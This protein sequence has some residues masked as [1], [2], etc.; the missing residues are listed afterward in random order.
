MTSSLRGAIRDG[1][2]QK[3]PWE[4]CTTEQIV[5]GSPRALPAPRDDEGRR[6]PACPD[7]PP[8]TAFTALS[9]IGNR[10]R[11]LNSASL[12]AWSVRSAVSNALRC[13]PGHCSSTEMRAWPFSWPQHC[14]AFFPQLSPLRDKCLRKLSISGR[15][16]VILS[17][18]QPWTR[19]RVK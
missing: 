15:K 6:L 13:R 4:T 1:A 9:F 16:G 2:I 5:P 18:Y 11:G 19:L 14:M 10:R 3:A 17:R 12:G 8:E 7:V